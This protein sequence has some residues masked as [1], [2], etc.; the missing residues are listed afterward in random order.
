MKEN[1][2]DVLM[3]LFENYM[4]EDAKLYSDTESLKVELKEA[5]FLHSEINKAFDWLENL[6]KLRGQVP[7]TSPNPSTSIRVYAPQE[8]EK[9]DVTSRGFLL[10]LEQVGVLDQQT[11][12]LVIDRAM[13]LDSDDFDI[14]QLKW[15]VLMVMFNQP[16]REEALTWMEDMVL[17]ELPG[18]LH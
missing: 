11:R 16:G 12:E 1:V 9:L 4:D 2:F 10:F 18:N 7:A 6:T 5:G 8:L 13:A 15:V 14:D 3:Y 17:D